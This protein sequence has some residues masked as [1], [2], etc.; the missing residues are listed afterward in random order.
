[1]RRIKVLT[2]LKDTFLWHM[3]HI[4]SSDKYVDVTVDL[5]VLIITP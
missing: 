4:Y 1:M 2:V 3:P 5:N